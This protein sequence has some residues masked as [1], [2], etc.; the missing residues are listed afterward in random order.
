MSCR[1]G[2]T[3]LIPSGR[4]YWR[5]KI[6]AVTVAALLVL[7]VLAGSAAAASGPSAVTPI[8]HVV[9]IMLENHSFD[10]V[11]GLYPTMN[12]TSPGPLLSSL[13]APDD[14]LGVPPSV[15]RTLHQVP[16]GT[17]FTVN[18]DEGVYPADW[19]N[20]KMDGIEGNR[21]SQEKTYLSSSQKACK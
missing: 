8:R 6:S 20:G 5:L 9:N 14:V 1:L 10:N 18:P 15:A 2:A 16:N 3:D 17:Y 13:Q 21:A 11:F 12:R 7:Q 19:D 4:A